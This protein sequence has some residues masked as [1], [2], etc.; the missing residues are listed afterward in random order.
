[1]TLSLVAGGRLDS[2]QGIQT[3]QICRYC[4]DDQD[5]LACRG[6]QS[7]ETGSPDDPKNPSHYRNFSISLS[8]IA[9]LSH[10]TLWSM[11]TTAW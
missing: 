4:Q 3:H 2:D 11:L 10:I 5:L 9:A 6:N 1:M 8:L 7:F